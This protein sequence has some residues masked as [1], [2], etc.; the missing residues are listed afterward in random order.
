MTD[1]HP[2]PPPQARSRQPARGSRLGRSMIRYVLIA[3]VALLA[4]AWGYTEIKARLTHVFEYDARIATDLVTL[5]SRRDGQL[6]AQRW[7]GSTTGFPGWKPGPFK[8]AL[9]HSNPTGSAWP[10]NSR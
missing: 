4:L 10:A 1:S 7:P 3:A 2:A 6:L 9:V 5:S 8:R